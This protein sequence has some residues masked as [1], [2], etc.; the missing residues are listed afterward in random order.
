M[1]VL[2]TSYRFHKLSPGGNPTILVMGSDNIDPM[3]R[4]R[5]A[6]SL[7]DPLHLHAEQVGFVTLSSARPRLEMMGGEFCG[8]A[9]RC[10]AALLAMETGQDGEWEIDAS[11]VERPLKVRALRHGTMLEAWSDVP[12]GTSASCITEVNPG[13]HRVDLDG[14]THLLLDAE[15]HLLPEDFSEASLWLRDEFELND[16]PAVGC[17]WHMEEDGKHAIFPSVWVRDTDTTHLETACGSGTMALAQLIARDVTGDVELDVFQPSGGIITACISYDADGDT[18]S[19]ASIGGQ[20]SPV[21]SG[22]AYL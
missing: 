15:R 19:S 3:F 10:L 12:V 22:E 2:P 6:S 1:S 7:M 20:V 14:I 21:A 5:I 16:L 17:I 4:P 13:I 11:G 9:C 18:F 8:N